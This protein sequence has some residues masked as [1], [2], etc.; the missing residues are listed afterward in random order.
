MWG[1]GEGVSWG[2][3]RGGGLVL[4]E[5][6]ANLFAMI[7]ACSV[8]AGTPTSPCREG[9]GGEAV[10]KIYIFTILLSYNRINSYT[11]SALIMFVVWSPGKHQ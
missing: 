9:V 8:K 10:D 1:E 2:N 7:Y 5:T 3:G 4:I 11:P 6:G